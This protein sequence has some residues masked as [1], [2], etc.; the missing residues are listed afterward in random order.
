MTRSPFLLIPATLLL[1]S[2]PASVPPRADAQEQVVIRLATLAPRGST[3]MRGFDQWNRRLQ[4]ETNGRVRL[5]IYP[6]GSAGDERTVVRKL[7]SGQLDAAVMT[8]TGLGMIAREVLVLQAPGVIENYAQLDAVRRELAPELERQFEQNGFKLL[9]WGDAGQTRLFSK[10][11]IERPSQLRQVRPWV[12]RDSPVF[13]E[14]LRAAGA[15]GIPL[16][17]PEV[18]G[19]LSTNRVDTVPGSALAAIAL[20]WF[21]QIRFMSQQ[22]SG[23]VVGAMVLRKDLFDGLPPEQQ[24]RVV[25][26]AR[27]NS[28][29][30]TRAIRRADDRAYRALQQRGITPVDTSAHRAEWLEVSRRARESLTGRL[31]SEELLTRVQRIAANAQ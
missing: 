25:Q 22:S 2:L 1:L 4:S 16:A 11:R 24:E 15:N 8:T 21:T 7:R 29:E 13:V 5:Q 18:L 23:A 12:W 10:H 9:G 31:F 17:L 20:Q 6:G 14:F 26:M 27:R 19:G 3:W 30:L 28:A